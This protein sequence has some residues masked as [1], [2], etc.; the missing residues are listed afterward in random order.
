VD[1]ALVAAL[2]HNRQEAAA[3]TRLPTGFHSAGDEPEH[4]GFT[5][6]SHLCLA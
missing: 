4:A 1:T 5:I 2:L 6:R 3:R